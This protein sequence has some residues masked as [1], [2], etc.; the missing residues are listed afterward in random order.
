M[1]KENIYI[2]NATCISLCHENIL[3]AST[4]Y[5]QISISASIENNFLEW[6]GCGNGKNHAMIRSNAVLTHCLLGKAFS[7]YPINSN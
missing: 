1:L 7:V 6:N 3:Y 5:E 2:L 4:L